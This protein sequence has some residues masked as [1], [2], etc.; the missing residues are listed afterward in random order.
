MP[1]LVFID[2]QCIDNQGNASNDSP[3][4][5]PASLSA[6]A[7]AKALQLPVHALVAGENVEVLAERLATT[8]GVARVLVCQDSY[9]AHP[10]AERL[11]PL[12]TQL[13]EQVGYSHLLA[14]ATGVGKNVLPRVAAL[15]DVMQV[16]E[17]TAII[18]ANTFERP[19]YAGRVVETVRDEQPQHVI[20]VKATH[21]APALEQQPAVEIVPVP[22]VNLPE[23]AD[24][25][26]CVRINAAPPSP[27]DTPNLA[28][29]KVVVAG[30]GG[31]HSAE[32]FEGLLKPLARQ[33]GA[34]I[35]AS[36]LPIVNGFC[37]SNCLIGQTGQVVA[38]DLYLAVGI[39]GANQ[40]VVGMQAAKVVI[41]INADKYAP[42][43][44]YADYGLVM[45]VK[46]A[47]PAL[48]AHYSA[49]QLT[50]N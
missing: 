3:S 24:L 16:S 14:A 26:Q 37:D 4:I 43:F 30:G 15:L 41:A 34:A 47:L 38:P 32:A 19:S 48:C 45:D 2:N 22:A 6:L 23:S 44:R 49:L 29:A 5:H 11:A 35:G 40:H 50:E 9:Y 10:L 28:R 36:R 27:T 1:V 31:L 46:Q 25:S 33:L 17:A 39:S 7:A 13:M 21:F 20:T 8:A 18:D 42:I 12:M